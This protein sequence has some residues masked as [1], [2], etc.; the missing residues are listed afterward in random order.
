[1]VNM[2]RKI[3]L[4]IVLLLAMSPTSA[5]ATSIS[6]DNQDVQFS[7]NSGSPFIDSSNRTQV[8][9]RAT[10]EHFGCG[11]S[12]DTETRTAIAEKDGIRVEVPINAPYIIRNGERIDND[13]VALIKD[14]R[15]Y[16]PIRAVLEAFGANVSWDNGT[17]TVVVLTNSVSK[18][19]TVHF[20]DVGQGD[21]IFIDYDD[22]EILID[23][24]SKG[25]GDIVVDY[26][27]P[28]VDG[29][30]DLLIATHVHED[31]IG[32]I[33]SVLAAFQV[34]QIID[35]RDTADTITFKEYHS[36]A[37]SE[38]NCTY[39]EDANLDIDIGD[40]VRLTI[41][42]EVDGDKNANN[43]SVVT[44]FTYNNFSMLLT[45]DSEK[46]TEN[47]IAKRLQDVNVLKAGHHGSNTASSYELLSVTQPEVVIISAGLQNRYN[48]PHG[49]VLLRFESMGI[50]AFGTFK[51]GNIVVSTNGYGYSLNVTE[52]L[53]ISDAGENSAPP[54]IITSPQ[55]STDT[56]N[57]TL[58]EAK[59]IGN[60]NTKKFHVLSCRY[61]DDI[62]QENVIY[63]KQRADAISKGFVPC[64]VCKP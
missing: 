33:P 7:Q 62:S 34:S 52:K 29:N 4:V 38:P 44:L 41:I 30:L 54:A 17:Q 1:M 55:T 61:A 20:I 35:S 19:M 18:I 28:Y 36:A 10:M 47:K 42:D 57:V 2:K 45:G 5:F 60:S 12:W 8:P 51:S 15:T 46:S 3:L 22:Y 23:A 50:D 9:F 16:L 27:E 48:H 32:G 13:T 24:G 37:M 43:N 11:V 14:N 64:K 31:H 26:I 21:S 56:N 53:N 58:S 40:A 25:K 6:I 63:F 49:E 59:Y 39:S